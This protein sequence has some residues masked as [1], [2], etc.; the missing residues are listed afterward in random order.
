VCPVTVLPCV[1]PDRPVHV[2]SGH[3]VN[4]MAMLAEGVELVIGV[5][6]HKHTHTAAVVTA[7]TGA[8]LEQAT[9][10][11]TPAGYQ[12]LVPAGRRVAIRPAPTLRCLHD[13]AA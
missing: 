9:V 11:A 5:D 7:T 4:A 8:V 2:V 12:Q 3:R 1:G 6:T 10:S 13:A